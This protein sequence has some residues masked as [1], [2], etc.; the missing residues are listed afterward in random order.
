MPSQA[1]VKPGRDYDLPRRK[2]RKIL[3]PTMNPAYGYPRRF[4]TPLSPSHFV[5]PRTYELA[6]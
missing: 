6:T 5:P 2:F 3:N 4:K 1:R